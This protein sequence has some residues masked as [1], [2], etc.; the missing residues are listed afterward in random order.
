MN[1]II[2][3]TSLLLDTGLNSEQMDFV[4]MIRSSGE[5]LLHLINDI[6]DFSKLESAHMTLEDMPM[7]LEDLFQETLGIFAFKAAEKGIQLNCYIAESMPARINGDFHRLKQV[8]VNLV[9]NAANFTERGENIVMAQP[10]VRRIP[11]QADL[12]CV[13]ISVRDTGIGIPPEKIHKLFDAFMQADTSTTR[14]YG[15]TGLGLAISRKIVQLMGG[16]IQVSSE[17][18]VGSN[19]YFEIAL[20]AAP[21]QEDR[22]AEEQSLISRVKGLTAH[23]FSSHPT[24]AGVVRHYCALWGMGA[25]I[26]YLD[27]SDGPAALSDKADLLILDPSPADVAA[28]IR[29]AS[30]A[31]GQEIPILCISELGQDGVKQ[32]L[33]ECSGGRFLAIQKPVNRREL[34]KAV[35]QTRELL[36]AP[37]APPVVTIKAVRSAPVSASAPALPSASAPTHGAA[38][39][40]NGQLTLATDY[41]ARILLVEDQ[42]MNQKLG[43]LMLAKL[44][45]GTVDLAENGCEAVE[46]IRRGSYDVVFMDLHMPVMGGLD[47]TRAVRKE[48]ELRQPI[49][50]ALTGDMVSG[51]RESCREC[52]MDDFL[53]KPVSV[54]DLKGV[55]IRNLTGTATTKGRYGAAV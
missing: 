30:E 11:D 50:V 55:I 9:G 42:P 20:R 12:P 4:R 24:T 44:G 22:L 52:G 40:V 21:A 43:R 41:P 26:T 7:N 2:G 46:K 27:G 31:R 38:A 37:A 23:I 47:A 13:H 36:L 14:K 17:P 45:Y 5:S 35:A 8:L 25:E 10:V 53:S 32:A 3:T 29:A 1:G 48:F 18:G 16:E 39:P 33:A 51:V 19:F 49:I 15:G 54:D 28:A 6:L 34:L